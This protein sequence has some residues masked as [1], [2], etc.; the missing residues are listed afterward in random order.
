M[1]DTAPRPGQAGLEVHAA[2]R[3][4]AFLKAHNVAAKID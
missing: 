2:G 3:H 1:K 4:D